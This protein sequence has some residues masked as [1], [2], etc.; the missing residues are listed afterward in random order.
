MPHSLQFNGLDLVRLL[1]DHDA[2]PNWTMGTW[3]FKGNCLHEA[4]VLDNDPAIVEALLAAGGD[5]QFRD[6]GA[7]TPLAVATCLNRDAHATLFRQHGAKDEEI[8][9]VDHWVSACFAGDAEA[10]RRAV[11]KDAERAKAVATLSGRNSSLSERRAARTILDA[12]LAPID[13]VGLC[14]A[15]RDGN[16]TAVGL[17]LAGGSNPDAVDDDGNRALHLAA[18][19][20]NATAVDHLVT[21]GADT[22][23]VNYIGETPYDTAERS[24]ATT[25]DSILAR[26]APHRP[27]EPNICYD[28]P[29]FAATF[30]R[31]ADAV[32]DGDVATLNDL[33][34]GNPRLARARSGRPHRCT[35]LHYLGANTGD[36]APCGR[37][38]VAPTRPRNPRRS[39]AKPRWSS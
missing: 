37:D 28:D 39:E 20:G 27:S 18:A 19:A 8:R 24:P 12:W 35:L 16:N 2:D 11:A 22:N 31:A 36:D 33:L 6:Q 10:A 29:D 30:E 7:R 17:L 5:T 25:R 4:V 1:L 14:R 21:E 3:G 34:R 13:D 38:S 32:V 9:D 15:V 23:T 26:L